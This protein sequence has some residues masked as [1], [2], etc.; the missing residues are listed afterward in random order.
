MRGQYVFEGIGL[1][2]LFRD[3]I[4]VGASDNYR[5]P[6]SPRPAARKFLPSGPDKSE[7]PNEMVEDTPQV[8]YGI[9]DEHTQSTSWQF[10]GGGNLKDIVSKL[11]VELTAESYAVRWVDAES[12]PD[13]FIEDVAMFPRPVK[14]SP[15]TRNVGAVVHG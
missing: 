14:F 9:P 8:M 4:F 2:K 10:G 11:R 7:L 6:G 15:K 13:F 3:D 1:P 5:K 12:R